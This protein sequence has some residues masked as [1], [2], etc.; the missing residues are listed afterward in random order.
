MRATGK[1]PQ[2]QDDDLASAEAAAPPRRVH[3]KTHPELFPDLMTLRGDRNGQLDALKGRKWDAVVDTSGYV[4]RI[5]K[6]SAELLAPSV[7]QTC[8]SPRSPCSPTT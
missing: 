7:K 6:M 4:P 1:E 8:S 3:G 5:V 2:A